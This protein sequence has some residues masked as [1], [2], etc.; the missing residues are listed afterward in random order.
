MFYSS[1]KYVEQK[2]SNDISSGMKE[3]CI[4]LIMD[5][6]WDAMKPD[7]FY[8]KILIKAISCDDRTNTLCVL[9]NEMI[10]YCEKE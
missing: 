3:L 6:W 4:N 9:F 7:E 10:D 1:I 5:A 2:Q 8:Q